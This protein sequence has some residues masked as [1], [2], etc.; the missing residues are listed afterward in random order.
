MKRKEVGKRK[1]DDSS[2]LAAK[3]NKRKKT[4]TKSSA[5]IL[6][7]DTVDETVNTTVDETFD[8]ITPT[9]KRGRPRKRKNKQEKANEYAFQTIYLMNSFLNY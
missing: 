1:G 8:S 9:K 5:Q 4:S 3:P 6:L 2:T 7:N